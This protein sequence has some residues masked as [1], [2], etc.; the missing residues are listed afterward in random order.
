MNLS[1]FQYPKQVIEY[2]IKKGLS[3]PLQELRTSKTI[4]VYKTIEKIVECLKR[5]KINASENLRVIKNKRQAPNLK[6]I[7]TKTKIS[8]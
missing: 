7:L 4:Q 6:K 3:I 5:K 2:A 8:Q 1:K